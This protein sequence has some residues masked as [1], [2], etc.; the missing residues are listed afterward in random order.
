M[1]NDF[2]PQIINCFTW[3]FELKMCVYIHAFILLNVSLVDWP[4]SEYLEDDGPDD[5]LNTTLSHDLASSW[6]FYLNRATIDTG[7]Q[8]EPVYC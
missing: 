3:A 4:D 8:S 6:W 1:L 5:A 2:L 7:F